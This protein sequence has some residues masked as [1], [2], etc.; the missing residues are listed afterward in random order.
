MQLASVLLLAKTPAEQTAYE[1][2]QATGQACCCAMPFVGLLLIGLLVLVIVLQSNKRRDRRDSRRRRD[3]DEE[4]EEDKETAP[5]S[6]GWTP[7]R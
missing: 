6:N 5:L 2:G 3:R 4:D 1:L 7:E